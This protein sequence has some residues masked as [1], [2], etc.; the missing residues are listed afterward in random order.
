MLSHRS[1]IA[2]YVACIVDGEMSA[3]DIEVHSLPLYHYAQLHCFLTPGIYLGATNIVLPGADPATILRSVEAERATKLFCPPTVWISPLRHTDFDRRDVS[4]LR[5]GYY[6]ASIM[7][8]EVLKE[9]G[10]RL[11]A[12][13]LFNFYGQTEMAPLATV[14]KPEDQVRKA[15]WGWPARARRRIAGR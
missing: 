2:Q 12:V 15:G 11:P 7:P 8:V 1:L 4:S 13:R 14:L 3:D 5:K 10:G 9:I 6:G